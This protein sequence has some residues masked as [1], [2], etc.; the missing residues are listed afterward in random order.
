MVKFCVKSKTQ[1]FALIKAFVSEC[2]QLGIKYNNNF[3]K[4]DA[5]NYKSHK[6]LYFSTSWTNEYV[7]PSCSLTNSY[8]S[9]FF[10]LET[11]WEQAFE[12]AKEWYEKNSE[13]TTAELNANF[14]A[15]IDVNRQ[16]VVVGCQEFKFSNIVRLYNAIMKAE[17]N[18]YK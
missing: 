10:I 3:T 17:E 6:A 16:I 7:G 15:K 4:F 8:D 9:K 18:K 1:S 5:E 11:E 12:Y 14:I 13:I 2:E